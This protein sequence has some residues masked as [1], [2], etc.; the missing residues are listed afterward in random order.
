[1][2]EVFNLFLLIS[3]LFIPI[4]RAATAGESRQ[5]WQDEPDGRGTISLVWSC[6]TTLF[7]CVWAALHNNVPSKDDGDF[8][9]F[10]RKLKWTFVSIIAPEIVTAGAFLQWRSAQQFAQRMKAAGFT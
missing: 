8:T 3:C 1:M 5:G 10:F 7:I 9:Y 4:I 6:L 2:I